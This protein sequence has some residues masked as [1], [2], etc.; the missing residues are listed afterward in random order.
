MCR[1]RKFSY[2]A[3]IHMFDSRDWRKGKSKEISLQSSAST[4]NIQET[5]AKKKKKNIQETKIHLE[6]ILSF[7]CTRNEAMFA[8]AILSFSYTLPIPLI[9]LSSK[10][11]GP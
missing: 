5:L 6:L 4:Q 1:V 3:T 7:L 8:H 2:D 11:K 10:S 9:F